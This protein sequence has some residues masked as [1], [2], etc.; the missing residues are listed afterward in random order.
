[1]SFFK[2]QFAKIWDSSALDLKAYI[3][4]NRIDDRWHR[5]NYNKLWINVDIDRPKYHSKGLIDYGYK[6]FA[7]HNGSYALLNE[8]K[9][10]SSKEEAFGD[11][12]RQ[13]HEI[14]N[15]LVDGVIVVEKCAHQSSGT[16]EY[17]E[18]NFDN[19]VWCPIEYREF[20]ERLS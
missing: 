16:I 11:I 15:I 6:T 13:I 9:F 1:M 20:Q 10:F 3:T 8:R 4:K 5:W 7:R 12:T 17:L 14:S 18:W 19:K 2:Q